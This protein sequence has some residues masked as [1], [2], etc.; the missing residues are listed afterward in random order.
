MPFLEEHIRWMAYIHLFRG[1][2]DSAKMVPMVTVNCFRHALH[3]QTPLR[4]GRVEVGLGVSLYAC[5]TDSQ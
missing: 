5:P 4:T 2:C 1:M 3:F